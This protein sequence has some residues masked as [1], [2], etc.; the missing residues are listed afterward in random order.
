MFLTSPARD[1]R[2]FLSRS[3]P[4]WKYIAVVL[5]LSGAL[6]CSPIRSYA[7][8]LEC[9]LPGPEM[10][11]NLLTELQVKLVASASSADLANEINDTPVDDKDYQIPFKFTGKLNKLTVNIDRPKLT[12][13]D[14]VRFWPKPDVR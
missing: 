6:N 9:P 7:V 5:F 2:Q 12:D 3:T 1:E 13:W 8:G 11:P 4:L 10:A 14:D